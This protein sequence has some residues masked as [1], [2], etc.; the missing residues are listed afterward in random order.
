MSFWEQLNDRVVQ[1]TFG[2]AADAGYELIGL[3]A[4]DRAQAEADW[5]RQMYYDSQAAW[6]RLY[7]MMPPSGALTPDYISTYD[8][9][10][11]GG[12]EYLEEIARQEK[13]LHPLEEAVA[14]WEAVFQRG[15]DISPG[16]RVAYERA[17]SEL[18][19]AQNNLAETRRQQAER[20]Q[21]MMGN[22]MV[23]D[24]Q[25]AMAG[26]GADQWS[27][28]A[29]RQ[30]TAGLYDIY[31]AGGLD[32]TT[33]A[34]N[35]MM[36]QRYL[37]DERSQREALMQQAYA[38]G[39]GGSGMEM[40]G[41]LA[42]QQQSANAQY[43]A[44]LQNLASGQQRAQTALRDHGSLGSQARGQSF[45]EDAMRRAAQD[46]F[47]QYNTDYYRHLYGQ[48]AGTESARAEAAAGAQQQLFE[49]HM[50]IEAGRTGQYSGFAGTSSQRE[51]FNRGQQQEGLR[52]LAGVAATII[53]G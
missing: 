27:I 5:Q 35:E 14:E 13:L 29:Q 12:T 26:A 45:Q 47:T 28:D 8:W 31:Q 40:Q 34:E 46:H 44:S 30:A 18:E 17:R 38:R 9:M 24:D 25:V 3:G 22:V 21:Q 49:N 2:F 53:G 51:M 42:N 50:G 41:Q 19:A 39:V 48:A 37:A 6:D 11:Q 10:G 1:P 32:E 33:R 20:A 4:R 36:R 7:G 16:H 23:G 43:M 15:G 52:G